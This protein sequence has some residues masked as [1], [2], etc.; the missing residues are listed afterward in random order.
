MLKETYHFSKRCGWDGN[1]EFEVLATR[2]DDTIH[3]HQDDDRFH[4]AKEIVDD[5]LQTT[6][7][8][9]LSHG[10]KGSLKPWLADIWNNPRFQNADHEPVHST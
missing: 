1:K 5:M 3:H 8:I 4:R 9:K 2:Y 6:F 10:P 7:M